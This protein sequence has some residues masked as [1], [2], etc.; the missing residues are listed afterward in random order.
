MKRTI[1]YIT[2]AALLSLAVGCGEDEPPYVAV[3]SIYRAPQI[4]GVSWNDVDS[5]TRDVAWAVGDEGTIMSY[6]GAEWSDYSAS[7]TIWNLYGVDIGYDGTGWAVGAGGT[8]L[9]FGGGEWT[10]E[11]PVTGADLYGVII[12]SP[13]TAWAVGDAGIV[14]RYNGADWSVVN[15]AQTNVDLRGVSVSPDGTVFIVGDEGVILEYSNNTWNLPTSPVTN[16]L[17]SVSAT[18]TG[19]FACGV[20][21]VILKR[22]DNGWARVSTSGN[23]NLNTVDVYSGNESKGFIAG[24][25]GALYELENGAWVPAELPEVANFGV[26]VNG[27]ALSDDMNGW[28]VG[29]NGLILRYGILY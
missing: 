6:N 17:S 8:V 13:G 5:A 4:G 14:L 20:E 27:V 28:A 16:K 25:Q 11:P 21:D 9:S 7:P 19:I 10:V 3:W 24:L 23:L 26:D 2:F 18:D 22:T 12:D 15:H 1:I 29:N